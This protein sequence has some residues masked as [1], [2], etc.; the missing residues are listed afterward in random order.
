MPVTIEP[1][2]DDFEEAVA[3]LIIPIQQDEFGIAITY[4]EQ[5][6]LRDVDGFYRRGAGDF[7]VALTEDRIVVGTI[8]LIDIGNGEGA[9]RKMFVHADHRGGRLGVARSLL[10]TLLNHARERGL[11][12]IY[13]GTTAKFLAAHRFY[14]KNGF[15]EVAAATLPESF[16]RMAQ[17]TRFYRFD[18]G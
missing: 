10:D 18:L 5:P 1:F 3:G 17:D 8:A 6:D 4:E 9:L 11:Q 2:Q 13:L 12:S 16:P 7:W 14:E 15:V